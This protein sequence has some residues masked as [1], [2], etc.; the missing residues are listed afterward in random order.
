[1]Y[2]HE[3]SLVRRLE[4]RP[5]ALIGV[6]SDADRQELKKVIKKEGITWRSFW[7]GKSGPIAAEWEVER[8]PTLFLLDDRGVI[9]ET[10]VGSPDDEA[11]NAAIDR[12]VL[13]AEN[14]SG[15]KR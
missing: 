13:E 14:P 12:L 5:F 9:R 7:D 6:N 3:R 4:G 8:W 2:P 15:R 1:M 10:Y 11:L